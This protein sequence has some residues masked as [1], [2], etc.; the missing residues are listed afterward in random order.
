MKYLFL[1]LLDHHLF[2]RSFMMRYVGLT[3]NTG[4]SG[5]AAPTPPSK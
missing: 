2:D 1:T 4:R 3:S 5:N